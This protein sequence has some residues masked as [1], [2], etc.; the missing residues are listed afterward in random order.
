LQFHPAIKAY[1][2]E[3][4]REVLTGSR[5]TVSVHIRSPRPE[6]A[7]LLRY[8]NRVLPTLGWYARVIER[9]F[10]PS[11]VVYLVFAENMNLTA[12][13]MSYLETRMPSLSYLLINEDAALSLALMSMCKHHVVGASEFGFWGSY[14]ILLSCHPADYH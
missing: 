7:S 2:S 6:E 9:E 10:K 4:Y 8:K 12:S 14:Y 5:E 13:L 1:L 3:K 11:N